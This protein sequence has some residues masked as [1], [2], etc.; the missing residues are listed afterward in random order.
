MAPMCNSSKRVQDYLV[1]CVCYSLKILADNYETMSQA[2]EKIPHSCNCLRHIH[3]KKI[4]YWGKSYAKDI[5]L[6]VWV[7]IMFIKTL[8]WSREN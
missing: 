7:A 8:K 3:R 4:K 1:I 2:V 6:R 5:F